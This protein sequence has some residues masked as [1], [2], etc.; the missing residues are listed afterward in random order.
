MPVPVRIVN[1]MPFLESLVGKWVLV[2]IACGFEVKG[3]LVSFDTDANNQ[4][5]LVEVHDGDV[6][7]IKNIWIYTICHQTATSSNCLFLWFSSCMQF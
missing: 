2:K 5:T 3:R 4:L 7:R 1:G 6:T